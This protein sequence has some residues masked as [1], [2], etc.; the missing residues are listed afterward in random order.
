MFT[1]AVTPF[2][3]ASLIAV[4]AS[5]FEMP[6]SALLVIVEVVLPLPIVPFPV[7]EVE[8]VVVVVVPV[9]VVFPPMVGFCAVANK[10]TNKVAVNKD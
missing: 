4:E 5:R 3:S 6:A 1:P 7:V 8:G 10:V 9:P 2:D